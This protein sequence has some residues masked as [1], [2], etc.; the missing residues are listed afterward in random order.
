[1]VYCHNQDTHWDNFPFFFRTSYFSEVLFFWYK[2]K[3]VDNFWFT[4]EID[5]KIMFHRNEERHFAIFPLKDMQPRIM[6]DSI[7]LLVF[8]GQ[9]YLCFIHIWTAP[10]KC[11]IIIAL[12]K[13]DSWF[14]I[15]R[16]LPLRREK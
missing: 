12:V 15:S 5:W 13:V 11:S 10:K 1:M 3:S 9:L 4:L 2:T 16:G 7:D 6:N 14:I 8:F